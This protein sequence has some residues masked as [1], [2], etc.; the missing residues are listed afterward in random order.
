MRKP[1]LEKSP[2]WSPML[3]TVSAAAVTPVAPAI[4]SHFMQESELE[5]TVEAKALYDEQVE[6]EPIPVVV[7]ETGDADALEVCYF[8]SSTYIVTN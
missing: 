8:F 4:G 6:K 2:P 5:A 3:L 7:E 1:S